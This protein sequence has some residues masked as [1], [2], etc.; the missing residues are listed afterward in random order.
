MGLS[1][2]M[3]VIIIVVALIVFLFILLWF[4]L[5]ATKKIGDEIEKDQYGDWN[6][7]DK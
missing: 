3:W 4:E 6:E 1:W 7:T 5:M 2:W